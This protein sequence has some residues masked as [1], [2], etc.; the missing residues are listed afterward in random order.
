MGRA[1]FFLN[2]CKWA[3]GGIAVGVFMLSLGNGPTRAQSFGCKVLLCSAA[4]NPSWSGIPY[5]VPVMEQLFHDLSKGDPWPSCPEGGSE[6][7][8]SYQPYYGMSCPTGSEPGS[9][10]TAS[11]GKDGSATS[12]EASANGGLCGKQVWVQADMQSGQ[13][14][15]YQIAT[16][17]RP[18]RSDPYN[19]TITPTGGTPTQLWFSLSG[20]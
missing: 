14:S 1:A 16:T 13:E 9:M 3:S 15:G 5:C 8:I 18:R 10:V 11:S 20:Y 6:S 12:W 4:S 19:V 7:P 2:C 17:P